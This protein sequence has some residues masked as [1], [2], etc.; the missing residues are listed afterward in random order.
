MKKKVLAK[1]F[2]LMFLKQSNQDRYAHLL[3]EFRQSYANNQRD[4]FPQDLSSMFGVMRTV[5]V[6]HKKKKTANQS[7]KSVTEVS[8]GAESFA[9]SRKESDKVV[10][11]VCRQDGIYA[12]NCCLRKKIPEEKWFEN[13]LN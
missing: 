1:F 8:L 10:C 4:L 11:F 6:G 7:P 5:E 12:S 9:Q 13:L 2:A 3:K